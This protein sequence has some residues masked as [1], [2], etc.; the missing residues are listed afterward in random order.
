[1]MKQANRQYG[2]ALILVLVL[3]A[4]TASLGV[5]YMTTATV[6]LQSSENM[7]LV[8]RAK[9]VAESGL[10]HGW[11]VL[12]ESPNGEL[13]PSVSTYGPFRIDDTDDTYEFWIK[14]GSKDGFYEIGARGSSEGIDREVA[15]TVY[16]D[17][18]FHNRALYADAEAYWRLGETS[19]SKA[20]DTAGRDDGVFR[21]GVACGQEGA[22]IG[23]DDGAAHFDGVNDYVDVGEFSL[24]GQRITLMAWVKVSPASLSNRMSIITKSSGTDLDDIAWGL[25]TVRYAG[26]HF[27]AFQVQTKHGVSELIATGAGPDLEDEWRFVVGVYN[28]WRMEIYI[29][30]KLVT[31]K[32]QSGKL[33]GGKSDRLWIGGMYND[34][35]VNGFKGMIDEVAVFETDLSAEDV[36]ELYS[37]R[38]PSIDVV[39]WDD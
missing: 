15:A 13:G 32:P 34:S 9:F 1:M 4:I 7:R 17:N 36:A 24:S 23:E 39:S 11:Y 27:A 14:P 2:F 12:R 38:Y 31:S 21:N 20:E 33:S 5:A 18:T 22:L 16:M 8:T 29:D 19:G 6:K 37:L 3:I 10:E 30:G 25:G 35:S 28:G 26:R